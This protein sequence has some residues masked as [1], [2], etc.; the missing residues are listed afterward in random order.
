M[1][2]GFR[3]IRSAHVSVCPRYSSNNLSWIFFLSL[4]FKPATN[5]RPLLLF[6][7]LRS[8]FYFTRPVRKPQYSEANISSWLKETQFR[9]NYYK[10]AVSRPAPT[11]A[12]YCTGLTKDV[13]HSY[14]LWS[15][16]HRHRLPPM[17]YI[18]FS[19]AVVTII[20]VRPCYSYSLV[21]SER[22]PQ[23]PFSLSSNFCGLLRSIT[24]SMI[25]AP[26][27]RQR[28][29][30]CGLVSSSGLTFHGTVTL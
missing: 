19:F 2:C 28:P 1:Q 9:P 22:N 20:N 25:F 7:K 10:S 5:T 26:F 17:S 27:W 11:C 8:L 3:R 16:L 12:P 14:L 23:L 29:L 4:L 6:L 30:C 13:K 15:A 21:H 18:M 24:S